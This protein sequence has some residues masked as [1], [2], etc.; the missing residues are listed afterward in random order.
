MEDSD[1]E[2]KEINEA[3]EDDDSPMINSQDFI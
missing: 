2:N 1:S 3:S